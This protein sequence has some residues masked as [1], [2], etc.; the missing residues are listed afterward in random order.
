M[1]QQ[2]NGRRERLYRNNLEILPESAN[3]SLNGQNHSQVV[4]APQSKSLSF[5][6]LN[7]MGEEEAP[8]PEVYLPFLSLTFQEECH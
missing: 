3:V 1:A 6:L 5:F 2:I 8:D 4:L 7:N